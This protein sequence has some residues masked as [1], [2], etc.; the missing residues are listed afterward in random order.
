MSA[1]GHIYVDFVCVSRKRK[2]AAVNN[3]QA[4]YPN[5]NASS[6]KKETKKNEFEQKK[7]RQNMGKTNECIKSRTWGFSYNLPARSSY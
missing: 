2:M 7:I 1:F 5:L 6:Q 4:L 3:Q